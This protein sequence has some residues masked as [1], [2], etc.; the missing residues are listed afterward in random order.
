MG[1]YNFVKRRKVL[2][3]EKYDAIQSRKVKKR[4]SKLLDDCSTFISNHPESLFEPISRHVGQRI[5]AYPVIER[6]IFVKNK[7]GKLEK[8]IPRRCEMYQFL[9]CGRGDLNKSV[10]E[11]LEGRDVIIRFNIRNVTNYYCKKYKKSDLKQLLVRKSLIEGQSLSL[12]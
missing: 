5:L 6:K 12:R 10:I 8:F 3:A 1:S 7:K 11:F 4:L 2:N 9:Y